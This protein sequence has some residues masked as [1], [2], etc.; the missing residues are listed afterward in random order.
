MHMVPVKQS[1]N[2]TGFTNPLYSPGINENMATSVYA[3]ELTHEFL[4]ADTEGKQQLL[5]KY[6][7]FAME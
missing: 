3:A 4:N 6:E 7:V 5:Q 1:E 2:S